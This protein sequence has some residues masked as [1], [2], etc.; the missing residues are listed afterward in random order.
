VPFIIVDPLNEG[1][2]KM[3]DLDKRGL[4]NVAATLFNLLGFEKPKGY[5]PSLILFE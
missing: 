2:Y 1:E 3:A 4:S 5:D